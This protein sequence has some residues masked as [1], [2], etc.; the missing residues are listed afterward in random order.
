METLNDD[1]SALASHRLHPMQQYRT[2]QL[3][4]IGERSGQGMGC[5]ACE[6]AKHLIQGRLD[7]GEGWISVCPRPTW[8]V[9][10]T[11]VRDSCCPADQQTS[12][13]GSVQCAEGSRQ[14]EQA[15]QQESSTWRWTILP[16]RTSPQVLV[17][18]R[19]QVLSGQESD[20]ESCEVR[21]RRCH[22]RL[23]L[24]WNPPGE[25]A[26][27]RAPIRPVVSHAQ[28]GTSSI[29]IGEAFGSQDWH[30][31]GILFREQFVNNG[32]HH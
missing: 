12:E 8:T 1:G 17:E 24:V 4:L 9:T 18:N 21:Y 31:E 19:F 27:P 32:G 23:R 13:G 26:T 20:T 30:S 16:R 6:W 10:L 5:E 7:E 28:T 3:C 15:L 25:G 14:E 22:R 11:T 29:L 2:G